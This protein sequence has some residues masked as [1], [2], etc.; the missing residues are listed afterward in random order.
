L[1]SGG[2]EGLEALFDAP[3]L[4]L[5]VFQ[6]GRTG[7]RL[8]LQLAQIGFQLGNALGPADE[9]PLKAMSMFRTVTVVFVAPMMLF[10][11]TL[12]ATAAL[13]L[14]ASTLA[15]A[16]L[17]LALAATAA[18]AGCFLAVAV[19]TMLMTA[20]SA[21]TSVSAMT[22]ALSAHCLHSPVLI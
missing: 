15:A 9:P 2:L 22:S 18:S 10:V 8:G 3:G 17:L 21:A 5:D 1:G 19:S 6:I 13:G 7:L 11:P 12:A 20:A 14:A 4:G 16:G